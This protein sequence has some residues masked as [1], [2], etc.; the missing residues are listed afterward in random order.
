M[1]LKGRGVASLHLPC[2]QVSMC[3][4]R[5]HNVAD[6]AFHTENGTS[7]PED[8]LLR[9]GQNGDMEEVR[10]ERQV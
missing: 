8:C 10:K 1:P 2:S 5:S 4:R 7:P 9:S 6:D 3:W